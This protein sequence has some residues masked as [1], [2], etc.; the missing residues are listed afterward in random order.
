MS[1]ILFWCSYSEMLLIHDDTNNDEWNFDV[2]KKWIIYYFH[3]LTMKCYQCMV[4]LIIMNQNLVLQAKKELMS[5]FHCD[6]IPIQVYFPS[7]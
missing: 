4:A 2:I 3:V 7:L 6:G 1:E 5:L